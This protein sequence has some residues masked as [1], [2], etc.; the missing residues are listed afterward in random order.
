[1]NP[2]RYEQACWLRWLAFAANGGGIMVDTD[3]FPSRHFKGFPH[4]EEAGVVVLNH[5][6][7]PCAVMATKEGADEIVERAFA[8]GPRTSATIRGKPHTSDMYMFQETGFLRYRFCLEVGDEGW[9]S[10]T[11]IHFAAGAC[12]KLGVTK[13]DAVKKYLR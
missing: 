7:V 11:L 13:V 3:V 2:V 9:D 10:A 12:Q 4:V 5:A 6:G 8:W 1:V